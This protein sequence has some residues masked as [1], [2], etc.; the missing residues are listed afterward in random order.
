MIKRNRRENIIEIFRTLNNESINE[1]LRSDKFIRENILSNLFY[2]FKGQL[3]HIGLI[4][5][6]P[7][8]GKGIN[9]IVFDEGY[10]ISK[11]T[12]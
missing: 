4:E 3:I 9:K 7:L 8:W 5:S 1:L 2:N 10:W 12:N 6:S 11:E